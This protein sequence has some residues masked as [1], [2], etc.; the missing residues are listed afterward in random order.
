MK[1]VKPKEEI[2]LCPFCCFDKNHFISVEIYDGDNYT[3]ITRNETI[4]EK[5]DYYNERGSRVI[6]TYVCE[7]CGIYKTISTFHEGEIR[8]KFV[9]GENIIKFEELWRD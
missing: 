2:L 9:K 8:T 4:S 1:N 5:I 6:I 3:K 7:T